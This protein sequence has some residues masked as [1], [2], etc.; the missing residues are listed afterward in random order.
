MTLPPF[1]VG[2]PARY[3]VAT[4]YVPIAVRLETKATSRRI[5]CVFP[6]KRRCSDFINRLILLARPERFELPTLGSEDI[7][8]SSS[9]AH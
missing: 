2:P 7:A 1:R 5:T 3:V 6:E 8:L 4:P 9:F